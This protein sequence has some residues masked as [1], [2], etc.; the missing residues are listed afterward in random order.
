MH[1][2]A[3]SRD[4][5]SQNFPKLKSVE[6]DPDPDIYDITYVDVSPSVGS[7]SPLSKSPW[8][9][10]VD[11]TDLEPPHSGIKSTANT[12]EP[13]NYSPNI[14]MGSLFREEGHIYSLATSGDLLYTGS[15]SKNIRVWKNQ[16]EFSS[17]KSNSGLVKAIVLAGDKIFTGHQDGKIRVWKVSSKDSNI[18]RRIGTMPVFRDYLRNSITPSSYFSFMR[19]NPTSTSAQGFRHVDAISCLTLSEDNKLLY[20][21][22]WDQTF[23]VW[24]ISDLRCLE[25]VKAHDDAVNAVVSG[26]DGLV[27]SGSA[28]GTVKVWRREDQAKETKHFFSETL[29]KQDCAVT[30]I[31]VDQSATL[32]YCGSSDGT[33]NFWE[34]DNNMKNGGVLKGHKLAVLCLV[35]AGSL[36]FSGS[37]DLGIRVWRRP[38]RG[39]GRGGDVGGGGGEHVCIAVLKGHAGPVKCMAVERDQESASGEKRWI[40]YSGSLDRS[41]KMWRVSESSPPIEDQSSDPFDGPTELTM[42]PSF[43]GKGR[44]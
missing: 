31:A 15:D 32:V 25:S 38:E 10:H 3:S 35:A 17:F 7:T 8:I 4:T 42:A 40:V 37:A 1:H 19:K 44:E 6:T 34:R 26:F 30:A 16:T 39:D 9:A 28:D 14:L 2:K 18:F 43:S 5:N 20:S 21:G 33:V 36:L 29:L 12:R 27:F 23:K 22:S 24:R 41:V 13:K 11:P